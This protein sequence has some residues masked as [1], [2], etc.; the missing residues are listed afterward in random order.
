MREFFAFLCLLVGTVTA[1]ALAVPSPALDASPGATLS[2]GSAGYVLASHQD[3]L[4]K[5]EKIS[6]DPQRGFSSRSED[7]RSE[8]TCSFADRTYRSVDGSCNNLGRTSL[9]MAGLPYRRLVP[10]QHSLVDCGKA[11]F[12]PN[13]RRVS[14]H[15]IRRGEFDRH[16]KLSLMTMVW[17]QLV[18][19]DMEITP[20]R[21]TPSGDFLDCC[22]TRNLNSP[23]C[24]PIQAP[25][26]DNFYGRQGRP[27]CLPFLRSKLTRPNSRQCNTRPD[28]ENSN[29]PFIDSSFVYGSDT[30]RVKMLRTFK[31][32]LLRTSVDK[33]S[34]VFPPITV[35]DEVKME[36]G[37]TRGDVHPG[38]TLLTTVFLRNHNRLARQLRRRHSEWDDEK[39]YQEARKINSA[40]VQHVTYT[41]FMDGLLGKPNNVRVS[42]RRDE[43]EDFYNPGQDPTISMAFSTAGYRLH[44]YVPGAFVLRDKHYQILK[45]LRLR[46][47]FHNPLHLLAN[48]TYDDL[49]RGLCAQPLHEFNNVYSPEMTEWLF[50][51]DVKKWGLD[52]VSLNVQRGRDHQ[53]PGYPSYRQYCGLG[54]SSDWVDMTD[55]IPADLVHRLLRSYRRPEDV[56]LYIGGNLEVPVVGSILGPTM[57]CLV[58]EQF[59]R[60]RDGDRFFYTNSG[61]FTREQLSTIKSQTLSR[62]LCDNADDPSEM[63]LP[64]NMFELPDLVQN[65]RFSCADENNLPSLDIR[66]W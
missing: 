25:S 17:G 28:V 63:S 58:R 56:D 29:T 24:C 1:K 52:I 43:H 16:A 3:P 47:V 13:P 33:R 7:C 8:R 22:E 34:R 9:G 53:I 31:D 36:F 30:E 59:Q 4:Y 18:D 14:R 21:E 11:S 44:T 65:R 5:S 2:A 54:A 41:Q 50:P 20:V 26:D 23:D 64:K 61:Q 12:L 48:N 6:R 38:F 37:D 32:G 35:N 40:L 55:F 51:E 49:A 15:V 57:H 46:D 66:A 27:S 10:P 42:H 39:I 62:I 60:L 19:H 45:S